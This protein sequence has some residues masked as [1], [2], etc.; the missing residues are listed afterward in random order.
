MERIV[1]PLK[2]RG[3][4]F[5]SQTGGAT[6]PSGGA[7]TAASDY[8][9]FLALLMNKG[10]T[11][12]GKRILSEKSVQELESPQFTSLPVKFMP[13]ELQGAQTGLGCYITGTGN[14]T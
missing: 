12:D 2:M 6:N 3:T 14:A 10:V 13:K 5:E 9:S 11:P 1:R 4:T 7:L 8:I